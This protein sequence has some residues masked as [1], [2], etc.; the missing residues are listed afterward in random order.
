MERRGT[1]FW[2]MRVMWKW[3]RFGERVEVACLDSLMNSDN[4]PADLP[5]I[6]RLKKRKMCALVD[7]SLLYFTIFLLDVLQE[8]KICY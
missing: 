3:M 1:G 4:S 8:S 2:K 5:G 7:C 6:R